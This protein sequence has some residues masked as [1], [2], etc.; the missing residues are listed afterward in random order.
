MNFLLGELEA[1]G[2]DPHA[3]AVAALGRRRSGFAVLGYLAGAIGTY[4]W[5]ALGRDALSPA[6]I[7]SVVGLLFFAELAAGYFCSSIS[8]MFMELSGENGRARAMFGALGMSEFI[9]LLFIPLALLVQAVSPFIGNIGPLLTLC[10]VFLQFMAAAALI[11]IAYA[12]T[13]SRAW[14]AVVLPFFLVLIGFF[15]MVGILC[16]LAVTSIMRLFA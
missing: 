4:T 10:V 13:A 15:A 1:F 3:A 6:R 14:W 7:I 11:R 2:T 5:V 12:T 9:K 16:V 8:H